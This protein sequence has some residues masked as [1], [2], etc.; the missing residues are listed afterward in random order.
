VTRRTRLLLS[1]TITVAVTGLLT[2]GVV[3]LADSRAPALARVAADT[4]F[5][6]VRFAGIDVRED[7]YAG[8]AFERDY[9]IPYPSISDPGAPLS[10]H[11][12]GVDGS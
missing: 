4:S 8:L 9:R 2:A 5:L 10:G 1:G 11:D 12:R 7:P 6:G 3:H